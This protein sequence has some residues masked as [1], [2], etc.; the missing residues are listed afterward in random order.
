MFHPQF[1]AIFRE[2]I[3]FYVCCLYVNLFV[4]SAKYVDQLMLLQIVIC[5]E[6]INWKEKNGGFVSAFLNFMVTL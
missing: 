2:H 3:I 6:R 1:L 4:R 5:S